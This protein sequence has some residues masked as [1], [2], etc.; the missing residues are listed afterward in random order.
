MSGAY[1]DHS[2]LVFIEVGKES[3]AD[4]AT[5]TREK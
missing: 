2:L 1:H 5:I 4:A 3:Y